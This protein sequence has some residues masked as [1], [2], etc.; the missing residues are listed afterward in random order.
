MNEDMK[1]AWV[2]ITQAFG[3]PTREE[4]DLFLR[5]WQMAIKAERKRFA[6]ECIDMVAMYGGSQDLEAAIRARGM[7]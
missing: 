3:E 2:E 6:L 5:T 7:K 4:L 1:T